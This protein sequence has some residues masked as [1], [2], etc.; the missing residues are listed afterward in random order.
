MQAVGCSAERTG[1]S[2][3]NFSACCDLRLADQHAAAAEERVARRLHAIAQGRARRRC[4]WRAPIQR[5]RNAIDLLGRPDEH[6]F[7]HAE[8]LEAID[9]ARRLAAEAVAGDVED[10]AVGRASARARR[11]W[12]RR[13]SR[14]PA[15]ARVR[16]SPARRSSRS[17]ALEA[18]DRRADLALAAA[19]RADAAE[20]MRK[21]LEIAGFLDQRAAD[22]RR[23]AQDFG[24]RARDGLRSARRAPRPRSS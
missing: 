15:P 14:P 6:I 2:S 8:R 17:P 4:R 12:D 23:K 24:A 5:S 7:A 22:H 21:A 11:P 9:V 20:Q 3:S 13:D 1:T 18:V 16:C 10:Q 19:E